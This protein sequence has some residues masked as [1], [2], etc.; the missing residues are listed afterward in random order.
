MLTGPVFLGVGK[1][2]GEPLLHIDQQHLG[3]AAIFKAVLGGYSTV[4][5]SG[6]RGPVLFRLGFECLSGQQ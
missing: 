4:Q 3:G 6:E 1:K 2:A 5:I